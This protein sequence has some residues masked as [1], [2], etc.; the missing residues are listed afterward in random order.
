[1]TNDNQPGMTITAESRVEE[2]VEQYPKAVGWLVGKGVV[3]MVC[4]E[5]FWG[6]LGELMEKKRIEDPEGVIIELNEFLSGS[7]RS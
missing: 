6:T 1:M 3:C 7:E 2:I 4:G 5:P